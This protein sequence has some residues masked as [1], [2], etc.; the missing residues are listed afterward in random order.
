MKFTPFVRHSI[1]IISLLTPTGC[2][3]T[4]E[5]WQA[6]NEGLWA[7]SQN[8]TTSYSTY[9]TYSNYNTYGNQTTFGNYSNYSSLPGAYGQSSQY[10]PSDSGYSYNQQE[11]DSCRFSCGQV[12]DSCFNAANTTENHGN[13]TANDR[14]Y[15]CR[16]E[17]HSC[18]QMCAY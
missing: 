12:H 8:Q 7:A 16:A 13:G 4:A 1:S 17:L 15:Y 3:L 9:S 14:I 6:I 5:D 18:E 2:G 10:L 11:I